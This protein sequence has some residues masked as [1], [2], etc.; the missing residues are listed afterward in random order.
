[1]VGGE[2]ED[3]NSGRK[4]GPETWK[5]HSTG[6]SCEISPHLKVLGSLQPS[7]PASLLSPLVSL[8]SGPSSGACAP[9]D[10]WE[11][12]VLNLTE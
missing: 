3:L 5:L 4:Q 6:H 11:P 12:S 2:Q 1:M 7:L 10:S 8:S 9:N